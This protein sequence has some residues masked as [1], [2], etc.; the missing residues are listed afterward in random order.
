ML[1]LKPVFCRAIL[2]IL[3][4]GCKKKNAYLFAKLSELPNGLSRD[5]K[6]D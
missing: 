4:G 3:L 6:K 1:L 5:R 2:K